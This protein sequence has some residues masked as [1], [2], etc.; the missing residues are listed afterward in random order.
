MHTGQYSYRRAFYIAL[1]LHCLLVL[2]VV[3]HRPMLRHTDVVASS[4]QVIQAKVVDARELKAQ[5]QARQAKIQQIA[6][7]KARA[8]QKKIAD[9]RAAQRQ[10]AERKAA[11]LRVMQQKRAAQAA[12][13]ARERQKRQLAQQQAAIAQASQ[14]ER[15]QKERDALAQAQKTQQQGEMDRYRGLILQAIG[16]NWIIPTGVDYKLSCLFMVQLA[17][18]GVVIDV[19]LLRSS[20]NS[21]LDN[22]AR[23][24]IL[25]SSPL[26]VPNNP[27]LFERFRQL[28]LKVQPKERIVKSSA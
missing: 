20:H 10:I 27:A 14:A 15:L 18:G 12:K 23:A 17:P 1:A 13:A 2:V 19:K 24:A 21:A 16:N 9:E 5:E 22:S 26:P 6:Q 4:T 7:Q 28:R 25:K 8:Q 11:A 3:L